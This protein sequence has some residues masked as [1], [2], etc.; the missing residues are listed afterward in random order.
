MSNEE[1]QLYRL[2]LQVSE[3]IRLVANLRGR[4]QEIEQQTCDVCYFT[5]EKSALKDRLLL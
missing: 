1:K 4:L 3:L 2:E 5:I